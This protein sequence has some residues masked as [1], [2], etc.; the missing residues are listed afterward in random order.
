MKKIIYLMVLVGG[1]SACQSGKESTTTTAPIAVD[2]VSFKQESAPYYTSGGDTLISTLD[3]RYPK[4]TGGNDSII[5]KINAFMAAL[6]LKGLSGVADPEGNNKTAGNLSEA[7]K[8]FFVAVEQARKEM[9]DAPNMV[10][11]YEA[12]GD[13]LW[14]SP[15][16]ISLYY[17]ES[18]YTG[19]A[20][21]N[22]YTSFYNFDALTGKLL[23]LHEI[24]KD[25]LALNKLAEIKFKAEET[26]MAKE[27]GME[28]KMEDYFFP[29]NKFI[30][31]QNIGISKEGLRLLYNPYEVA[32]YARGMIILDIPW[33][34]LKGI[35]VEKYA[36]K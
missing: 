27:N 1:I 26:A 28:F 17:N 21:G 29:E 5:S 11:T 34:E 16:V 10:Y 23:E 3:I 22:Y 24:V 12:L 4:L 14:I 31:P 33:Q 20:H 35:V 15:G 19:G 13:T 32:A 36:G 25:T 7:S 8:A 9:P 6:P 2:S 18:T 30:L